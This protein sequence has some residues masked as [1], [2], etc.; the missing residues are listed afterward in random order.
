MFLA[1]AYTEHLSTTQRYIDIN[2]S[3]LRKA[4]ELLC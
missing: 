1:N 4:V 2:D 3:K